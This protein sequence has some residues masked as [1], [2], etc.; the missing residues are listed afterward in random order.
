MTSQVKTIG[1]F[2]FSMSVKQR[3]DRRDIRRLNAVSVLNQLRT[4]G[5]MSRAM[6]AASLGLTRATVSNIV[7]DLLQV[8]VV[9][10]TEY[11]ERGTGRPGLLLNL[12]PDCGSMIAVDV[13][14]DHFAVVLT[15]VGQDILWRDRSPLLRNAAPD[16]VMERVVKLVEHAVKLSAKR[17][18]RCYGICVAW[19]GLVD[20]DRG[21][22]AYGP[23]SGWEH[24]PLKRH[25]ESRFKVPVYVE[26]EAHAGAIGVH[27]FGPRPGVRNLVYLSLGVGLGAGVYVDGVLLRGKQ[28]FAGQVGHTHFLDN[29]VRC[30]CG[31]QGCWVTEIGASGIERKLTAAGFTIPGKV[32]SSVD[33]VDLIFEQAQAGNPKVL[34]VLREVGSQ[35]GAG[36]AL[37]VQTFNPSMIVIGGRLG[38]AMQLVQ[39][40][41]ESAILS[42]TLPYMIE[43]LEV[44]VSPS[45][46]DHIQGCIA[47]VFDSIMKN[48]PLTGE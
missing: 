17:N 33:W 1:L 16:Q 39:P 7:K 22:L 19:A 46:E 40:Q 37:L 34:L 21:E 3:Y 12:N 4:N 23:T 13:N 28:G 48:P 35:L 41:I 45:G 30:G 24:V 9:S 32:N 20:R 18:L 26:N 5:P 47:T 36:A 43:P 44:I 2:S 15:N 8:S 42:E 11:N 25:W 14:L 6:I 31:K 38:R 27:H 29:G 10:E